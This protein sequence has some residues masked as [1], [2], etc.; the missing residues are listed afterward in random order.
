MKKIKIK[1]MEFIKSLTK[2]RLIFS[3][4]ILIVACVS[5]FFIFAP[6]KTADFEVLL[7]Q[8]D[9]FTKI[10]E[11]EETS[12][13]FPE[14]TDEITTEEIT[15]EEISEEETT[16]FTEETTEEPAEDKEPKKPRNFTGIH[17]KLDEFISQYEYETEEGEFVSGV[18][19]FYKDLT[20]GDIYFYNPDQKYF[21]ASLIKA[22]YAM[23]VYRCLIELGEDYDPDET[24]EYTKS[25]YR[26][27]TGKIK[28][29]DYGTEFTLEEL[30]SYA[31]RWSDNVAMDMIRKIFPV[32]GFTK[33]FAGLGIPHIWDIKSAVNGTICAKCAAVYIEAIY[34]F[35]EE[36]NIYSQT[37]KEHMLNTGNKMIYARYPIARKYGWTAEAFHDMGIVYNDERPYLIAILSDRGE[38]GD[39]PMFKEISRAIEKYNDDK[40]FYVEEEETEEIE[41]SEEIINEDIIA[42]EIEPEEIKEPAIIEEAAEPVEFIEPAEEVITAEETTENFEEIKEADEIDI[43]DIFEEYQDVGEHIDIEEIDEIDE[44]E[45]EDIIG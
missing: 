18:S 40:K 26:T 36:N 27:G 33:Y 5:V 22:P 17:A 45:V 21:I 2:K 32:S 4:E 12:E 20:D 14:E 34:N 19:V 39:Y 3:A 42:I 6:D 7:N 10:T 41:T 8:E 11:T 16:E 38:K 25:D 13:N 24:Y 15:T 35:I 31:I 43:F 9:S 30:L 28:N 44:V 29:M 23:Y 37:L 1:L